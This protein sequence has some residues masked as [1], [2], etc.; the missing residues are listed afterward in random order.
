MERRT[1]RV[2]VKEKPSTLCATCS[3]ALRAEDEHG[4]LLLSRCNAGSATSLVVRSNV[5]T[6]NEY[7]FAYGGEAWK[8]KEI[9]WIIEVS[10]TRK[11]LGFRPPKPKQ[12]D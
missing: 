4:R 2:I 11:F 10:K 12:N 7:D 3:H 1:M 5:T 8:Y 9:A 6:C